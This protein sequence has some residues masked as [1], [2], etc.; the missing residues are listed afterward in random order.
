MK[1]L[2]KLPAVTLYRLQKLQGYRGSDLERLVR[3]TNKNGRYIAFEGSDEKPYFRIVTG[4]MYG[5]G[6]LHYSDTLKDA[7]EWELGYVQ[8]D[9]SMEGF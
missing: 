9:E 4:D 6:D 5:Y 3:L 2:N 1:D 8:D 7:I